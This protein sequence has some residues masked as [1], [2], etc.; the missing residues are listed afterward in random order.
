MP[1][2]ILHRPK[3]T[4]GF[5]L[6]ELMVVIVIIGILA[7]FAIPSYQKS[8]RRAERA[9]ARAAVLNLQNLQERYYFNENKY[10]SITNLT[11]QI[12]LKSDDGHYDMSITL[13]ANNQGYVIVATRAK[14]IDLDCFEFQAASNGLTAARDSAGNSGPNTERCWTK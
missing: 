5:S 7:A 6:I 1:K 2:A 12:A 3:K 9:D 4:H 8:V 10:G 13:F 11:G 14:P